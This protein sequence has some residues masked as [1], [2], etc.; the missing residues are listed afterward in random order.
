[1]RLTLLTTLTM[2][3]FAANSVLN[4]SALAN[5]L[6][7]AENFALYRVIAGA[8]VLCILA[9][10]SSHNLAML[11]NATLLGVLS[12]SLYL[13]GF[14]YAYI[15]IDTGF[16]ALLLF[17]FVQITM[18]AY[19]VL[20]REEIPMRRWVGASIAFAGLV[21]LL[22]P[23]GQ[24]E[25]GFGAAAGLM[26]AAAL[27]W[28]VYSLV[29]QRTTEP[30]QATAGNFLLAVPVVWI[31]T[32]LFQT[33]SLVP[34]RPNGILLAVL[35][36][37]LTSG[38]GYTVWYHVSPQLGSTRAAVV[39]LTVPIIAAAGGVILLGESLTLVLLIASTLVL[40]GVAISLGKMRTG[41]TRKNPT[42]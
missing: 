33:D 19:G 9:V 24:N 40:G 4:R 14:S 6:I 7:S 21:V 34:T 3:A 30:L 41:V 1:M 28:G 27:G 42:K 38:L 20:K 16:G 2:I 10:I 23:G 37:A 32:L 35:S 36:G 18:F 25:A 12:L 13:I 29:G 17:G 8:V 11:R 31:S 5:D 22:Y 39:Q 15:Q 26:I